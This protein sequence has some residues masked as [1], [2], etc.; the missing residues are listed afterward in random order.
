MQIPA[1]AKGCLQNQIQLML[2]QPINIE[3]Y[4]LRADR[5]LYALAA[6][7]RHRDAAWT[8]LKLLYHKL[9]KHFIK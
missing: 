5:G 4:K 1:Q 9:F 6:Q 7:I 2:S 8:F 3:T